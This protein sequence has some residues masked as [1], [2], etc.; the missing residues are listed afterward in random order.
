MKSLVVEDD[1]ICNTVLKSILSHF[2]DCSTACNGM[3]AVNAYRQSL[4]DN[5][6]YE[7]VCM[8]IMMPSMDGHQALYVIRQMEQE[9]GITRENGTKVIMTTCLDSS[10]DIQQ[11]YSTGCNAYMVKPIQSQSLQQQVKNLGLVS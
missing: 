6:P 1:P 7:L 10:K 4:Q 2:G 3:E 5:E 9:H 11:A 8:D